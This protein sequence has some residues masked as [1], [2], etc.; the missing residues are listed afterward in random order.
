MFPKFSGASG[1]SV[2]SVFLKSVSPT[3]TYRGKVPDVTRILFTTTLLAR[4]G[5]SLRMLDLLRTPAEPSP[6]KHQGWAAL[7]GGGR[8]G[9][10][11]GDLWKRN[12]DS[13]NGSSVNQCQ[14]CCGFPW[15]HFFFF[16]GMSGHAASCRMWQEQWQYC[17]NVSIFCL[18]KKKNSKRV[19]VRTRTH[20]SICAKTVVWEDA[21][22][23][24]YCV[25][26]F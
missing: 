23:L 12:I 2:V 9:G 15:K 4:D 18:T 22:Y 13:K 5:L 26:I 17:Q 24:I 6:L 20:T 19:A 11:G 8:G 21:T 7:R 10:S 16:R 14:T 3:L 25:A 1:D